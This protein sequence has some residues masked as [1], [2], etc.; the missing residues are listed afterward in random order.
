MKKFNIVYAVVTI[1]LGV[2]ARLYAAQYKS[3]DRNISIGA[4]FFPM[5][6]SSGL[7]L[8]GLIILISALLKKG[9]GGEDAVDPAGWRRLAVFMS[10]CLAYLLLLRPLGF[11]LD[12]ALMTA[13]CMYRL[14]C[15]KWPHL[16]AYSIVMPL[17]VFCLFYY[18]MYVSLPLGVLEPVLPKY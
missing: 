10:A 9:G 7:V 1:G 11:I 17:V 13:L 6:M 5:L 4:D 8:T 18:F 15:R 14:G 12:S 2:F 16:I 3:I